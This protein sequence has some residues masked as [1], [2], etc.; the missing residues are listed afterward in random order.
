MPF[1]WVVASDL[2]G[3]QSIGWVFAPYL[4]LEFKRNWNSTISAGPMWANENYHDYFYEVAPQFVTPTRPAFDATGGYSGTRITLSTGKHY[5]DI[6][7]SGF[8]RYDNLSGAVFEDSPLVRQKDSFML[9]TGM[10]WALAK[11]ERM[12]ARPPDPW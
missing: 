7:I 5:G 4:Q 12:V 10:V 2:S 8:L 3:A 9:G 6:W 1:R 11:S